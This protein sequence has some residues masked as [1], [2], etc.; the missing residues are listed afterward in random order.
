[1]IAQDERSAFFVQT[2]GYVVGRNWWLSM[3]GTAPFGQLQIYDDRLVLRAL[4]HTYQFQR[5][6]IQSLSL[7]RRALSMGLRIEH[8]AT[9]LPHLIVFWSSDI[10]ELQE[11]L[12]AA[13]YR[14]V[15]T[16][17]N[18]SMKPTQS[19]VLR[20]RKD[21]HFCFKWLGGLFLSR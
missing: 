20:L 14:V 16:A 19:L 17:S 2:G 18:Q 4:F 6:A 15:D 13:D 8:S 12:E 21:P 9:R 7:I 11:R 1:M 5:D 10:D 3:H